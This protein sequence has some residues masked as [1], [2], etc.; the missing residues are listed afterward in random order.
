[1]VVYVVLIIVGIVFLFL[2]V[3]TKLSSKKVPEIAGTN[4]FIILGLLCCA[5]G[6]IGIRKEAWDNG[7]WWLLR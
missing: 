6:G 5:I 7:W 2:G 3:S 1:M 4:I